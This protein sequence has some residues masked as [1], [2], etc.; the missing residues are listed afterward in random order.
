MQVPS[1]I[2]FHIFSWLLPQDLV[3]V[4]RV[5]R[6]WKETSNQNILWKP[7]CCEQWAWDPTTDKIG[8]SANWKRLY[9]SWIKRMA[10]RLTEIEEYNEHY[11]KS[12][13]EFR[14]IAF[15]WPNFKSLRERYTFKI[16]VLGDSGIGKGTLISAF[17][18]NSARN[19]E[20]KKR[21]INIFEHSVELQ[22]FES[23]LRESSTMIVQAHACI[24]CFD[25]TNNSSF[26][27][28]SKWSKMVRG[29]PHMIGSL[30]GTKLDLGSK[31]EVHFN[32][33]NEFA[34]RHHLMYLE[35]SSKQN[36][37]IEK[38]F[39]EIARL[40]FKHNAWPNYIPPEQ[41]F[42][43]LIGASEQDTKPESESKVKRN[44]TGCVVQ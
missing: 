28:L 38:T 37:N 21:T 36:I 12:S 17:T 4:A 25:I 22:L 18:G 26:Q 19:N 6:V 44:S 8:E 20:A 23:T 42:R 5:S 1:D 32:Q 34:L 10:T 15:F 7:F 16:L 13:G 33:A 29:N 40:I 30:I 14:S 35:T 24:F 3:L 2:L 43:T 27:S 41:T 9:I 11:S 31:R 39:I